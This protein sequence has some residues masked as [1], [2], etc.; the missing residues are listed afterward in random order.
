MIQPW[1][2]SGQN[3]PSVSPLLP[4]Q[5]VTLHLS[6]IHS[7]AILWVSFSLFPL[8]THGTPLSVTHSF[9]AV[10]LFSET[11]WEPPASEWLFA[12]SNYNLNAFPYWAGTG[13]LVWMDQFRSTKICFRFRISWSKTL[14]PDLTFFGFWRLSPQLMFSFTVPT[15]YFQSFLFLFF[16]GGV[17]FVCF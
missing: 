13:C 2:L 3:I 16:L 14:E 15:L 4:S 10:F 6:H 1:G 5:P 8:H 12:Y 17:G 9:P 7:L 11:H